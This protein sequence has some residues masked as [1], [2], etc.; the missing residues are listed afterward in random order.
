[1]VV[2]IR[3]ARWG[4][5]HRPFY[6][7]VVADAR[8]PRDGRFI[9]R[10]GTYDPLP[11]RDGV[12]EVRLRSERIRYWLSC[13]AQPTSKVAWLLGKAGV[14]PEQPQKAFV[15][16]PRRLPWFDALDADGD[17]GGDDAESDDDV[18][19]DA[20]SAAAPADGAPAAARAFSTQ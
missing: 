17:G 19:V 15:E 6:R 16:K 3:L 11:G 8:A 18:T 7:I 10:V 4:R 14:L 12:K 20:A 13:G 2:R 1:M 9:E 5:K